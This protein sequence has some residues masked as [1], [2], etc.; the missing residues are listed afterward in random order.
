[1]TAR[2]SSIRRKTRAHRAPLQWAACVLLVLLGTLPASA[3][4]SFAGEW[5]GRYH[6]DQGD[7]VPGDVQGDFTGVPL[8]DAAR[9]YAETF[10]VTRVTLLEHQCQPY[11]LPHIY[12]GPLQFRI[13]D[14]KDPATQEIIAYRQYLGTY[15]QWRTI[16]MDG[17]PHPPEY[18]PHTFMGFS[19]GE[20]HGD[21]LTVTTTHIKKEFYRRSGIP[22]SDLTTVVEHYIRHGNLLSHITMTTDP[23][24]LTE[25][26]VTS[27][28]FVLMERGNQNWLYN[29]EYA[30]EIPKPKNQVPHF[31]PG[32]NPFIKDFANKFGLPFD[33]VFA[34]ADATYP[35]FMTKIEAGSFAAPSRTARDAG[36]R[37]QPQ[38][39]AQGEIKIFHVQ[40]NVYMLVGAGANVAVQIGDEGVVVVDTGAA[41]MREKVLA[42]MRQLSTKPIRWIINTHADPDHTGGNETIS[43]AG[44]TVNGNPAAIVAHEKVL[45]HMSQS[46]RPSTEW[47]LNTFFED[48]RDFYF[49]GEAIFLYHFPSGHSDGDVFVYF[50]SSDV[51]VA[52][53]LFVTTTYPVIDAKAGGGVD[54]FIAGL[55][56]MLDIAVPKYLQEGG[57][58]VIPGHGRVGDE[59]DILEYRDMIVII[60]DRIQDMIK[61]GMTLDQVKAAQ[62]TLD[63]DT[64]YGDPTAFVEAVYRDL[65]QKR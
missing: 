14:E 23:V 27:E 29:C 13:W 21:I 41:Q 26:Y 34:G 63:Y 37:P 49:N 45:A 51:L 32:K 1:M 33:A 3:Q 50:R 6:E 62:P 65:A 59:A 55:N 36:A 7:R 2:I 48:T 11:N 52:G 15:Q 38:P 30:M 24:Y 46:S 16:W 42:A 31:L 53:D 40:G 54:G 35:E 57:T 58:Y 17:R 43:Q 25:P 28:E 64:R 5:A 20:W 61:R 19:T 10:D 22:S 47:P 18:A 60:R 8:N 12:R 39:A 9:R 4:M 44:T 56:K